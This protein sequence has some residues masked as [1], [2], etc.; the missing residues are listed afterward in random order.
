MTP[1]YIVATYTEARAELVKAFEDEDAARF[2]YQKREAQ[3]RQQF[4]A[5]KAANM[6]V[7][8]K[9]LGLALPDDASESL[10][11]AGSEDGDRIRIT[12]YD[13]NGRE[14]DQ[15]EALTQEDATR[16]AMQLLED[17]RTEGRSL[18]SLTVVF[19]Q[20]ESPRPAVVLGRDGALEA[21]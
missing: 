4:W 9:R 20:P 1:E 8:A 16:A 5:N 21:A 10:V 3:E 2:K 13:G 18:N 6:T 15:A 7:A 14:L 17:A 11:E 19:E 12:T